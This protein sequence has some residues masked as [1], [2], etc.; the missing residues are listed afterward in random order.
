MKMPKSRTAMNLISEMA[1]QYSNQEALVGAN[2][3]YTWYDLNIRI[4]QFAKA[5]YSAGIK[6][7]D[8]VGILMG[9]HPDWLISHFG[10]MALGG[11]TVA[12][13]TWASS[14]ELA[15]QLHHSETK[16]L[17]MTDSF[18]GRDYLKL[19]Q[20]AQSLSPHLRDLKQ[21]FCKSNEPLP[22]DILHFGLLWEMSATISDESIDKIISSV[23]GDDIACILYTSGSTAEPKG[24]LLQHYALIENMW[25]IGERLHIKAN[26]RL[27]LSVSLFWGLG[28]E[29]A[30][31]AMWTHGAT[32]I[33]QEYF[34]AG[35][36]LRLIE[37]EKCTVYYGTP[38]MALALIEHPDLSKRNISSLRVGATLGSPSQIQQ[39]I[40]LGV[41]EACQI[42]GLTET[43][44]NCSIN[45][46]HDTLKHRTE[47]IGK[48]L[49][50]NEMIIA[51]ID[52]GK[53]L[54]PY[55]IGEIRLKGYITPGYFKDPEKTSASYDINGYF[56]TGDLGFMDENGY[57]Y[58]QGRVKELIKTGGINVSPAEIEKVLMSHEFIDE[59]YVIGL[60][61]ERRDEVVAAVIVANTSIEE[62]HLI[63]HCQQELA[64]Y[65][66]PKKLFFT[67]HLELPVTNTGKLKK[68][69][70]KHLFN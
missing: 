51:D 62:K 16:M 63:A 39:L 44:G 8:K 10:I 58:F 17:L 12:V 5:L 47:T 38:N 68:N 23:G 56:C 13:N 57:F 49:P 28:C 52:T 48:P 37:S 66:V 69:S 34:D 53:P 55:K 9:N 18:K 25:N 70:L 6:P 36:A 50:G 41:P 42:Y 1:G 11:V 7:G 45:D 24:V 19:L 14:R 4:R 22:N 2:I 33:L 31:F 61:D 21:I 60:P 40:D 46:S 59:A 65:K 3:R 29:N 20:E 54:V 32:I 67:T 26:D 64:A 15:Y 30:L 43:Y 27:W 35:E